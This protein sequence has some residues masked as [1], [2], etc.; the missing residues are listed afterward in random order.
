MEYKIKEWPI[1]ELIKLIDQGNIR[2][3]PPYQR[4]EIWSRNAQRLLINTIKSNQPIPNF[5]LLKTDNDNYEMV[6]GQQRSRTI[7]NY[8]RGFFDD[9][10]GVSFNEEFRDD[11]TN[12]D[13]LES[14]RNYALSITIIEKK[15]ENERIEDYYA[16][17]NSSGSQLNRPEVMKAKF[18]H[19]ELLQLINDLAE[20][21]DFCELNLFT[22]SHMNRMIDVDFVAELVVLIMLGITDKKNKVDD[23]LNKDITEEESESLAV[24]FKKVLSHFNRFNLM[25]PLKTT[26]FRQKNDFYS[27]FHFIYSFSHLEEKQFDYFYI[28]LLKLSNHISPSQEN[29]DPLMDYAI[30]CVTQSNSKKARENRHSFLVELLLNEEDEPNETQLAILKFFEMQ[31]TDMVSFPPY[32]TLNIDAVRDPYCPK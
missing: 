15:G 20:S 17:V 28:L 5:F 18:F 12:K 22:P 10:Q 11:S 14:F 4:N 8:W 32:H 25:E 23:M 7:V 13:E 30:N 3:D 19:T 29:C 2:L 9:T 16:L 21:P 31:K 24:A 26:R 27:L 6:D 1:S